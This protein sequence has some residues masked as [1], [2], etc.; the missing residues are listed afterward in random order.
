MWKRLTR[1][2]GKMPWQMTKEDIEAHVVWME[3]EGLAKSTI[4]DAIG[5]IANFYAWC[6]KNQTD[7]ACGKGFNPA[8]G[9]ARIRRRRFEGACMWSREEMK[10]LLDLTSRDS[11]ALGKREMAFFLLR[12]QTGVPLKRILGLKWGQIEADETGARVRWRTE[13]GMTRLPEQAWQAIGEYLRDSGRLEGMQAEKYVFT[14]LAEPGREGVGGSARDWAEERQLS[15]T[16]ILESLKIYGRQA[17]IAV[18]KLDLMALRRSAIRLR[19]EE[20]E[21]LEGMK[22]FMDSRDELKTIKHRLGRLA[23]MASNKHTNDEIMSKEIEVPSRK[24][25]PF[26]KGEH[27]THGFYSHK[28]D[29]QA[30]RQVMEENIQGME[31]E[32]ACLREL[33]RGI[34]EREV[35]EARLVEAYLQ[36]ARRLGELVSTSKP[37]ERDRGK[38]Y[39]EEFLAFADEFERRHGR[40]P[41][42][43]K[44][45]EQALGLSGD[46]LQSQ[47]T[48]AEEIAT[49]RLLLRNAYARAITVADTPEYL[50]IV[51]LY[52]LGCMRLARLLK[53]GGCDGEDGFE[54]N[55]HQA[56][57]EA[58][59]QANQ[60]LRHR[61]D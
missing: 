24:A 42:S 28:Q 22:R 17:G 54:R 26:K 41:L 37:S 51:D 3:G 48:V 58:I 13:A 6:D 1:Q 29:A 50:R 7:A 60:E 15:G 55:I 4:N 23:A 35:N 14:P 40:P 19:M 16:A 59:R 25:K 9:V 21:S 8:K 39:A 56:I 45:R 61:P 46:E 52:S 18:E 32:I 44:V 12:T 43:Q 30:V 47:G 57:D 5:I 27:T 38:G 10:A 49:V 31:Q 53:I 36:A 33:M 34:L 2:C 11:S 20:G